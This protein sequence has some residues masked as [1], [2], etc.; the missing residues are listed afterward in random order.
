M[1]CACQGGAAHGPVR[2]QEVLDIYDES[3]SLRQC[4]PSC[5]APVEGEVFPQKADP[6][7]DVS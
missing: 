2:L 3:H 7:P 4:F 6:D 1:A 5:T